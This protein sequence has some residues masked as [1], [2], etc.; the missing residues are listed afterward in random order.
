MK[1]A[2]PRPIGLPRHDATNY[3]HARF[4][5]LFS[6]FATKKLDFDIMKGRLFKMTFRAKTDTSAAFGRIASTTAAVVLIL[7]TVGCLIDHGGRTPDTQAPAPHAFAAT[8][9]AVNV[10]IT[11]FHTTAQPILQERCYQ[12]H[13]GV[14]NHTGIAFDALKT[15]DSVVKNPELWLRVLR[16]T[17]SHVMPP[18]DAD[19]PTALQQVAL[20][21]WIEYS[22]FGVDPNNLDPG[23]QTVRRLN[24]TEYRNTIQDL[25]GVN[26]DVENQFPSDDIGYGF[27]NIGDV[28]NVSPMLMEKYVQ[29]AQTIVAQSV[30]LK[31]RVI[32]VQTVAGNKFLDSPASA[33]SR[34]G[35]SLDLSF[36]TDAKVT[37]TFN[38]PVEGDYRVLLDWNVKGSFDFIPARCAIA[39]SDESSELATSEFAWHDDFSGTDQF[40]VHWA[41]GSHKFSITLHPTTPKELQV[42]KTPPDPFDPALGKD[43][44]AAK[45]PA[46]PTAPK[47]PGAPKDLAAGKDQAGVKDSADPAAANDPAAPKRPATPRGGRNPRPPRPPTPANLAFRVLKVQLQGPQDESHWTPTPG[48]QKFFPRAQVPTDAAE[49]KEYA[50]EILRTIATRAFRRPVPDQTLDRL[51]EISQSISDAPGGTFEKGVAQ[52]MVAILASPRFLYR[53][54]SAPPA[55]GGSAF[56]DVD[57]YSLASRLSYFLWSTMPDAE[58]FNL[59]AS[60][61]LRKNLRAQ[62]DRMLADP[63]SQALVENFTGQWLQSREVGGVA[64]SLYEVMLREG[65]TLARNAQIPGP[66]RAALQQEPEACFAYIMHGDRSVK[67]FIDSDYIFVNQTLA[68]FY[69]IPGVTGPQM[70]KVT[71]EPGD[72]RGGALTMGA[73]LIVTSNP[74]RTS[75]VKRGKWVLENILGAPAPPPPPDIPPLEVAGNQFKDQKPTLRQIL[76]THRA[77]PQCA[78]CHDRMDPLGLAMEN[79][80]AEGL[81]RKQELDQPIDASGQLFTGEKFQDI[82]ELKKTLIQNHLIEFYRCLTEKLLTYATGRGMEY[83]DMPTID[84]IAGQLDHEDGRFSVLLLGVIESAPFQEQRVVKQSGLAEGK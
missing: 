11:K 42:P 3:G 31:S 73:T 12:C 47:D 83:Y 34:N 57:E 18:V 38:V 78:S 67:E 65:V 14:D 69:K 45:D 36:F 2:R 4:R 22:A 55:G 27:D 71:L 53:V 23:R 29:A 17:R 58:L 79:F 19:P 20:E 35:G 75:P 56:V 16:N 21:N 25:M 48:Y 30:P 50:R 33:G 72:L 39:Y 8:R 5:L 32:P 66:V 7:G 10:A 81:Y 46:D 1:A 76:A 59:A 41:A 44:A 26:F 77:N 43:P 68:Q 82:G 61:Q 37:H 13:S 60:G 70:R 63:R 52:A 62:V 40:A 28:L 80:N 15:D 84:K 9:P 54:E 51:V 64:I 6:F 74:T 24:R 49:R